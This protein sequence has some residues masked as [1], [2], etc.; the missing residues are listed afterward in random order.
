MAIVFTVRVGTTVYADKTPMLKLAKVGRH[1]VQ[2]VSL[3]GSERG[4]ITLRENEKVLDIRTSSDF[5]ITQIKNSGKNGQARI[6]CQSTD[7][8]VRFSHS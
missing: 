1:S 8:K 6:S 3:R 4:Y 2:I 5:M 7:P